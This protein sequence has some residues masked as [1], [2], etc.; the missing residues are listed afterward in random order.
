[1]IGQ[2]LKSR[3]WDWLGE[4]ETNMRRREFHRSAIAAA[5]WLAAPQLQAQS[6]QFIKLQVGFAA[7]GSS[8]TVA[9]ALAERLASVLSQP[10]VVENRPGGGGRTVLS[11]LK[12]APA[13]GQTIL[14]T[15]GTPLTLSP[16]TYPDGKLGYDPFKDFT[17]IARVANMDFGVMINLRNP[18]IS[19][20]KTLIEY[21]KANPK[22]ANY[23]SPGTGT[24]PHFVGQLL[25]KEFD[26]NIRHVPYKGTGPAMNDFLG[27]QFPM[28]VDTLWVDRHKTKQIKIVAVTG[29]RRYRD[30]PDVPTLKELGIN[31]VVDQFFSVYAPAGMSPDSTRRLSEG[32]REALNANDVQE[33]LYA[34]GQEPAY[35]GGQELSALQLAQ[36]HYWEKLVIASGYVPE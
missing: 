22:D 1:M 18:A 4:L 15:P 29:E 21:L 33:A 20:F 17:P 24:V 13:D 27:G 9:R 23:A 6:R 8:D 10:V 14:L 30:L 3:Q 28:M 16:W 32:I 34:I 25:A 2:G 19:D 36:Y 7:G 11:E 31:I 5:F 12:R 35:L 26:L